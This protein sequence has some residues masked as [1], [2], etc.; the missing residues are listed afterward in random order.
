MLFAGIFFAAMLVAVL[1]GAL[2]PL[3]L[4]IYSAASVVTYVIYAFD[5][6]AAQRGQWRTKERTLHLFGIV[7]GWPGALIAQ[8]VF[9]HKSNKQPFQTVFRTTIVLNCGALL[10]CVIPGFSKAILSFFDGIA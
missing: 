3:V 7:G 1:M 4:A 5:K 2:S 10:M 6:T 8:R 9:R